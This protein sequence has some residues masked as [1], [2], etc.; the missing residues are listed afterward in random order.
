MK[1]L[2]VI[3]IKRK[4]IPLYC[5]NITVTNNGSI[6]INE[7][8]HLVCPLDQFNCLAHFIWTN[9]NL[10]SNITLINNSVYFYCITYIYIYIY[11]SY[12]ILLL[13]LDTFQT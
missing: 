7:G 9:L 13:Y 5:N 8:L 6:I 11:I 10:L 2:C 1:L 12:Y 3:Y 4:R